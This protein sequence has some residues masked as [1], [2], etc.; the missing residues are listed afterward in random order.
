[1]AV[2]VLGGG[3]SGGGLPP[4]KAWLSDDYDARDYPTVPVANYDDE[5]NDDTSMSGLLNGLA[6]RWSWRNQGTAT[7][8]FTR[9]G[10]LTITPPASGSQNFRI[11]EL[12]TCPD[13]T[14]ETR[15]SLDVVTAGWGG[16]AL[17]DG[18]NGDLYVYGIGRISGPGDGLAIVRYTNA[19]GAGAAVVASAAAAS[20]PHTWG[21]L[22]AVKS[23]TALEFWVSWDGMGWRRVATTTDIIGVDRIGIAVSEND[24]SGLTRL[25]VAYFRKVA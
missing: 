2:G 15:V 12:G 8:T 21:W 18:T 14:Y 17:I 22:R 9:D 1:M 25:H 10:W 5:F 16:M 13:G 20:S 11:I 24:S 23:G 7:A 19:M 4:A 3:T 6:G